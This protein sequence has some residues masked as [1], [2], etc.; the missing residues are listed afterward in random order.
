MTDI[1]E[2][3][4]ALAKAQMEMVGAK[5]DTKNTFFKS[6]YADLGSVMA[7]CMGALNGNGIAVVQPVSDGCVQTILI[8]SSGQSLECSIPLRVAKDDMQG[9]GSAI[10]YARR[11]GLMA[12]AG[13]APEDDDGNAAVKAPPPKS[14][15]T[16]G[17]EQFANLKN[18]LGETGS[19]EDK[20]LKH[21]GAVSLEQFPAAKIDAAVAKLMRKKNAATTEPPVTLEGDFV[22][23]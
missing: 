22:P 8:H 10:T 20:F 23:H 11:Y 21:F 17:P 14:E 1:N 15:Q 6:N 16:V 18:L 9:L 4:T 19:D 5:K 3:A 7:A 2:I 13:I 12:M